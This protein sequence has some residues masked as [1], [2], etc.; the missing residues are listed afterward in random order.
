ME[1][2]Q[3]FDPTRET[4][5]TLIRC[6]KAKA[7]LPWSVLLIK[8]FLAGAFLSFGALFDILI[9]GGAPALRNQNPTLVTFISSFTF[10]TGFV[11]LTIANTELFTA[12]LFVIVFSTCL[13]KNQIRDLAKN[14]V[15]SYVMNLAG[16][17]AVA[18]FLCYWSDTLSSEEQ[19]AYSIIQ[20]EARVNVKWSANFL[21]GVGCNWLVGM[22][23]FLSIAAKDKVSKVYAIWIPIWTFV[24][25]GYQH[26]IAN[27]FL[28]PI[29][30]FYGTDFGVGKYI[31]NSVIPV[32]IGNI[33]GGSLL[34][35]GLIWFICGHTDAK[36][37]MKD[38]AHLDR[39]ELPR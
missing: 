23:M 5:T 8:S 31:Y 9:A 2:T 24:A 10:P 32:T 22:A 37:H 39:S 28:V 25:L 19:K 34:D 29:G 12:N 15:S 17:L 20:A 4:T 35:A 18:G 33:V 27:F 7:Q 14:L 36:A 13:H 16:A 6:G 38:T 11:I 26:C 30:M 1:Q 3:T 21:R